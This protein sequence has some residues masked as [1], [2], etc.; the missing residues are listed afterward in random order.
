MYA[1]DVQDN[2]RVHSLNLEMIES[3]LLRNLFTF[4]NLLWR[5]A[6]LLMQ[7]ET[8]VSSPMRDDSDNEMI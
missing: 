5:G 1:N 8:L 4:T 2:S 6:D 3:W 7:K